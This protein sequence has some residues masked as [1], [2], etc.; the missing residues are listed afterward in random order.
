[1]KYNKELYREVKREYDAKRLNH[2]NE[3]DRRREEVYQK[4]PQIR[5]IEEEIERNGMR[6]TQMAIRGNG[7]VE[8]EIEAMAR[9][10]AM[11]V[12][13]KKRLL[14]TC[15]YAEDYMTNAWDCPDCE[16]KGEK[17]FAFCHCFQK[18]MLEKT[19]ERSN[20]AQ[21]LREQSF[22][23][24]RLDYYSDRAED[25]EEGVSP[26]VQMKHIVSRCYRFANGF[27]K[28]AQQNLFMFGPT[29]QGKT[30]LSSCIAKTVMD[31]G[32]SVMYQTAG[33]LFSLIADSK[34]SS[35]DAPI[36]NEV[37]NLYQC[38]LL[39]VDDVGTE[40]ITQY[41][42]SAFFELLNSRI[43]SGK[44]MVLNSNLSLKELQDIYSQRIAS[45]IAEFE[46]LRFIGKDDIRLM[47]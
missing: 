4:C 11:L 21:M 43:V 47:K 38:D 40:L 45:R 2:L 18:R 30:F 23:R 37:E 13:Q 44:K 22:D 36:K 5:E 39:I 29:G 15:G 8:R 26:R 42:V 20:M 3:L 28:E 12:E 35:Y 34:F 41:T 16:D 6:L 25:G 19:Y 31:Q 32:Y 1:M 27:G 17:D 46:I 14:R 7:D 24:V 33:T 10:N 9:Q